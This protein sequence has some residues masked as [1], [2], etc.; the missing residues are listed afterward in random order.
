MMTNDKIVGVIRLSRMIFYRDN[1]GIA[2]CELESLEEGAVDMPLPTL[3]TIKGTMPELIPHRQYKLIAHEIED[4]KYGKQYQVDCVATAIIVDTEDEESKHRFL[5][6]L[7]TEGQVEAMYAAL[8]DPFTAL[9]EADAQKLVQIK[10]CGAITADRWIRTFRNEFSRYEFYKKLARYNFSPT[11]ID[12]LI[13]YYGSPTL[14]VQTIENNPYQLVEVPGFGWKTV[15]DLVQKSGN[16]RDDVSRIAAFINCWLDD[17]GSQGYSYV[18][19]QDLMDAILINLGEDTPDN[20]ITDAIHKMQDS[21]WWNDDKT[22]IGLKKYFDLENRIAKELMRIKKSTPLY[23]DENWQD[24]V[25]ALEKKQG[26]NFNQEQIGA[27]YTGVNNNLVLIHGLAGT[28]KSSTVSGI[29]SV[30]P[31]KRVAQTALSGRAASRMSEITGEEGFTIHRLLGYSPMSKDPKFKQGFAYHDDNHLP[32]DI[33]ILDE[34]SMV[35]GSLFYNLL[36]AIPD[37]TK[38]IILGDS[39]QLES[40]GSCNI[41]HDL[42]LSPEIPSVALTEIHRQAQASAIITESIKVRQGKQIIP[43][44]WA[45]SEIRGALQD[46]KLICYSDIS[47]TYYSIMQE[48]SRLY[49]EIKDPQKIEVI[50]PMKI[51]GAACTYKLNN[52]IQYLVNPPSKKKPSIQSFTA[53]QPTTLQVGDKVINVKNNYKTLTPD[54]INRPIFNG[55]MGT[56]VSIVDGVLIVDFGE[57]TGRVVIPRTHLSSIELGY[58]ITTHKSQGSQFDHVIVGID[59]NSYALL[60]REMLYTAITRAKKDCALVAQNK[61]LRY[62]TSNEKIS[63]KKTHLMHCLYDLAHPKLIF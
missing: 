30:F 50:V 19:P 44:D 1:F 27:I 57:N 46:L 61:A 29:L 39:G 5:N 11:R 60:S 55:Q 18:E 40:I 35:D 17:Q 62:A 26:W 7:F 58:C 32:Y 22:A 8:A 41:A 25:H 6:M 21:L 31:D 9:Y 43:K 34:I 36:R 47:N 20:L 48:Y 42:M 28:G 51:R 63:Q 33:I 49:E 37:G 16:K 52:A 10:G 3:I 2:S 23:C 24:R 38:L 14:T 56:V 15:D 13:D 45:G 59:F 53:G 12:T 4:E 54:G